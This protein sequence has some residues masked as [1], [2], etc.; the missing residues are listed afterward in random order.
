MCMDAIVDDPER[1]TRYSTLD[2]VREAGAQ[3][4]ELM[5]WL[6]AR[7]ALTG[8]VTKVH[9]NYHI[10]IS[11]TAAALM[12]L[13]NRPRRRRRR[14]PRSAADTESRDEPAAAARPPLRPRAR[15]RR[16]CRTSGGAPNAAFPT[17]PTR[18]ASARWRSA[19]WRARRRR[20]R[21]AGHSMGGRVAL[22]IVRRA[23]GARGA[24]RAA[25]HRRAARARKAPRARTSALGR[26]ALLAL[27]AGKRACGRWRANG[28]SRWSIRR[29]R[30]RGADRCNPR[31][32]RA[33]HARRNSPARSRRCSRR[34]R[35]DRRRCATIDLPD[36]RA[37]RPRGRLGARR[38]SMRKWRR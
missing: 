3:G 28:C 20:S 17:M 18:R 10:P 38:R 36:A 32:V 13:E 37:V 34:P 2:L 29:G 25:R 26:L 7:G 21:V 14:A 30:R 31:H 5:T 23:P 8:S 33:P 9:S 27:G 22:E 12:V 19:C 24:A 16:C 4:T 15:G 35:R 6:A 11:N 1:L